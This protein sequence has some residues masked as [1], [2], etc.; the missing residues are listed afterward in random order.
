MRSFALVFNVGP[1]IALA[2]APLIGAG[3]VALLGLRSAFVLGAVFSAISVYF[4]SKLVEE[5]TARR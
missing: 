5:C 4:F 2:I 1:S 3:L